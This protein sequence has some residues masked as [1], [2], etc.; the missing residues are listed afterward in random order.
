MS[1]IANKNAQSVMT[2]AFMDGEVSDAG[3]GLAC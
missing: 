1:T 2:I 3:I